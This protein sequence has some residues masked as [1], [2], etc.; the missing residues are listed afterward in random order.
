MTETAMVYL[1]TLQG[2]M[3]VELLKSQLRAEGIETVHRSNVAQSIHPFT[4]NGLGSIKLFV[5]PGDLDDARKILFISGLKYFL[6]P[7]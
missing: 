5:S 2:M 1:C 3:D 7:D 4:V 6:D